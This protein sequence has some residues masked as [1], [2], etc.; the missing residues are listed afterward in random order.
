MLRQ[1]LWFRPQASD[2]AALNSKILDRPEKTS[3]R[4]AAKLAASGSLLKSRETRN[5]VDDRCS[6]NFVPSV[7]VVLPPVWQPVPFSAGP[8]SHNAA[9]TVDN[10][11]LHQPQETGAAVQDVTFLEE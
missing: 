11:N 1:G 4:A 10:D 5:G 9:G 7:R 6:Q 8:R 3:F 2:S